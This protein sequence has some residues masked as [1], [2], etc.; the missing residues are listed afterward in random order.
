MDD[1][2]DRQHGTA[3]HD[4]RGT[5]RTM[6]DQRGD[7][8]RPDH[9]SDDEA[10]A[11]D[12]DDRKLGQSLIGMREQLR[13]VIWRDDGRI[14][15]SLIAS[16]RATAGKKAITTAAKYLCGVASNACIVMWIAM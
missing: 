2:E 1:A 7:E 9:R 3:E 5:T 14:A 4:G 10:I 16:M 8:T 12:Y 11:Q 13:K 6:I 15:P